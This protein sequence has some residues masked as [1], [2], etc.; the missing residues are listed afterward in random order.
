MDLYEGILSRRSIFDFKPE[1]VPQELLEKVLAAGCWAQNHRLTE[2][3]RFRALGPETHQALAELFAT[4]QL[5]ALRPDAGETERAMVREKA[6]RKLLTRP[7]VVVASYVLGHDESHRWEELAATSCA[8]Q[9]VQL[10]AWGEGLGMQ[11]SSNRMTRHP[12]TYSLLGI[13]PQVEE[14]IGFLYF[15]FPAVVPEPRPRKPLAEIYERLP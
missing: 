4:V 11:W 13:D 12:A 8:I 10:A 15:G 5:E 1:P 2:P 7:Q 3:W 9:N 14:M 6:M